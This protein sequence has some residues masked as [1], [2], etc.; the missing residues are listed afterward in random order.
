MF[1]SKSGFGY[2][3]PRF[4]YQHFCNELNHSAY[5]TVADAIVCNHGTAPNGCSQRRVEGAHT[6]CKG[7][8]R[9]WAGVAHFVE[10]Q[11]CCA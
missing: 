11:L 5:H 9:Q 8:Y 7:L 3:C 10:W 1:G 6:R 2:F 4:Y